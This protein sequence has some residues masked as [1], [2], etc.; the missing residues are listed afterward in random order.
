M[1]FFR[2]FGAQM[3]EPSGI[4]TERILKVKGYAMPRFLHS[5]NFFPRAIQ[6]GTERIL[7]VRG[8]LTPH[9]RF[10]PI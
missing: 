10:M 1:V 2:D 8:N 7:Q 4:A 6:K 9:Y 5:G 3:S